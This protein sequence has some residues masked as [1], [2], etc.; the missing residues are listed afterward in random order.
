MC[1]GTALGI[2]NTFDVELCKSVKGKIKPQ[3][4]KYREALKKTPAIFALPGTFE[5]T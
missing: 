5:G 3:I 4:Q 1:Q 2:N